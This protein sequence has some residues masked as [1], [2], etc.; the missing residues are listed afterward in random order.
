MAGESRP[1]QYY[2][3]CLLVI[4]KKANSELFL[5]TSAGIL[6]IWFPCKILW[7][8][9]HKIYDDF[10]TLSLQFVPYFSKFIIIFQ[11]VLRRIYRVALE[12]AGEKLYI[13]QLPGLRYK[14]NSL[15]ST[16]HAGNLPY[17]NKTNKLQKIEYFSRES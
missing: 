16:G 11:L 13:S 3:W 14:K 12:M 8:D 9:S 5:K 15:T 2:I 7:Q 6:S 10:S 1:N 4:Y 17:A